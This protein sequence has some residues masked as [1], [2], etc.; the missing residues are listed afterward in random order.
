MELAEAEEGARLAYSGEVKAEAKGE[1][2]TDDARAVSVLST[3]RGAAWVRDGIVQVAKLLSSP[4]IQGGAAG[5]KGQE[6]WIEQAHLPD[7]R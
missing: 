6:R 1:S 3:S 2:K 7:T 4:S 5:G